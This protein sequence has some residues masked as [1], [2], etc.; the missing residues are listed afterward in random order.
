MNP[1]HLN[2][3]ITRQ[4]RSKMAQNAISERLNFKIFSERI[5]PDPAT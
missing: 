3:Q 1:M 2:L 5:P 4:Q